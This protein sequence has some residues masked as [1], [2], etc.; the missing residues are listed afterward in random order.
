MEKKLETNKMWKQA[1]K[2]RQWP[3]IN[4]NGPEMIKFTTFSFREKL[5]PESSFK[6]ETFFA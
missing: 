2:Y 3:E 5:K 4:K 1:K 6:N